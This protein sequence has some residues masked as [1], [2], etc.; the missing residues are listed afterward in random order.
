METFDLIIW[1]VV[2]VIFIAVIT[3]IVV[4]LSKRPAPTKVIEESTPITDYEAVSLLSPAEITLYSYLMHMFDGTAIICPKMRLA[5]IIQPRTPPVKGDW[6]P[7]LNKVIRKN[8][9]FVCLRADDLSTLGVV[10]LNQSNQMA[11]DSPGRYE[12]LRSILEAAGI[13]LCVV[14]AAE[15][16][17]Y[18]TLCGQIMNDFGITLTEQPEPESAG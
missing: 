15:N 11:P 1:G 8:L 7:A 6:R 2:L 10:E 4:V 18:E 14:Q 13:R 16:Y 17:D 3:V 12:S 5:D 9:D